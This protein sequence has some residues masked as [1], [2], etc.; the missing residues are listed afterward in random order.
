M[1]V[2][3]EFIYSVWFTSGRAVEPAAAAKLR[4]MALEAYTA[5]CGADA[6]FVRAELYSKWTV[7]TR[8]PYIIES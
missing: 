3:G 8:T 5:V 1:E 4:A 7:A 2:D 6:R